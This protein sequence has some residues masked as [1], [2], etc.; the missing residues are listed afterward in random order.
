MV[1][2]TGAEVGKLYLLGAVVF[3][4]WH[5]RNLMAGGERSVLAA[6][7][8]RCPQA[9]VDALSPKAIQ[10]M[11]CIALLVRSLPLFL[12]WPVPVALWGRRQFYRHKLRRWYL[13]RTMRQLRAELADAPHNF[14]T[15]LNGKGLKRVSRLIHDIDHDKAGPQFNHVD[16]IRLALACYEMIEAQWRGD[17][18]GA[19]AIVRRAHAT[20]GPQHAPL[21]SCVLNVIVG[22]ISGWMPRDQWDNSCRII[23]AVLPGDPLSV[24]RRW[25]DTMRGVRQHRLT[26]DEFRGP[27]VPM[28]ETPIPPRTQP[29]SEPAGPPAEQRP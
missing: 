25:S 15:A 29:R 9:A 28:L 19:D 11:A 2:L 17:Y 21:A 23:G 14:R 24:A 22:H 1:A 27:W 20:Y 13:N 3:A 6:T 26:E 4:V 5:T 7:M 12:L 18:E 8:K 10:T 16:L